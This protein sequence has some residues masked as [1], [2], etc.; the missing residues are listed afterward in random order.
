MPLLTV[1]LLGDHTLYNVKDHP[2]KV[3]KASP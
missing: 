1:A 2:F 3:K